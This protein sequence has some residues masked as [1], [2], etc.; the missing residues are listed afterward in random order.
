MN[1]EWKQPW[2]LLLAQ[3]QETQDSFAFKSQL[4]DVPQHNTRT[5]TR[6]YTQRHV[7]DISCNSV[8]FETAPLWCLAAS[9][10]LEEEDHKIWKWV[11]SERTSRPVRTVCRLI[12]WA[13]AVRLNAGARRWTYKGWIPVG[14]GCHFKRLYKLSIFDRRN[15]GT[16]M[17]AN[18][19]HQYHHSGTQNVIYT[20]ELHSLKRWD[21]LAVLHSAWQRD[22]QRCLLKT[23]GH[24]SCQSGIIMAEL[25]PIRGRQWIIHRRPG[26]H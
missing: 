2:T 19:C 18:R 4:A 13:K 24:F 26:G 5:L 14:T 9:R 21:F 8:N 20:R 7:H 16:L 17:E 23:E 15:Y 12:L 1:I 10:T 22:E 6:T 25:C 11:L 3:K